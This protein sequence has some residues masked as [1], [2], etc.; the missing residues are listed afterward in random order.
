M[1]NLCKALAWPALLA[2]SLAALPVQGA[3]IT[4]D[5][6]AADNSNG[7]MPAGRYAFLGV[8]FA[9]TD[10]G[11]TWGGIDNGDPGNWDINGTNGPIF[12]GYNGQSYNAAMLFGSSISQ[13]SLE[14]SRAN[15]SS[16]GN[17]F[18]LEGYSSAIL[19]ETI[20]INLSAINTW[21]SLGLASNVDEVRWFGSGTGVFHPF[22]VDNIQWNEVPEPTTLLLLGLGLA[23]LGFTSR[24]IQR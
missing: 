12:S 23:G 10:D 11:S 7:P 17:T 14:V 1:R 9:T 15:G 18:T 19:V 2:L 3:V 21:S 6:F 13:F 24:R 16:A 20:T 22:G 8:T 5:E 4:F